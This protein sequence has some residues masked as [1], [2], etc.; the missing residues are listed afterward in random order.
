MGVARI[1]VR[2]VQTT[3]CDEADVT[4][5]TAC[6]YIRCK[7]EMTIHDPEV[8]L[9]YRQDPQDIYWLDYAIVGFRPVRL[10]AGMI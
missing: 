7:P 4:R 3:S 10:K 5:L 9:H 1:L 6:H 2:V 8:Q